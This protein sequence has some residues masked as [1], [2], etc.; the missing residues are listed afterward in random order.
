M[1]MEKLTTPSQQTP[2]QQTPEPKSATITLHSHG[3]LLTLTATR[4]AG[5]AVT[6]VTTKDAEKKYTRGM[7]EQHKTFEA[8][9][10]HLNVLA[11]KAQKLGWERRTFK[12]TP[13]PDAFSKLPAP[14]KGAAPKGPEK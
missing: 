11:E 6:T 14:P 2:A 5:S 8:A 4:K 7:T 12:I 10:A 3:S 13:R 9:K 1:Q